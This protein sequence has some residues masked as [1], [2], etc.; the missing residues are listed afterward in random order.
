MKEKI[1]QAVKD[2]IPLEERYKENVVDG[3]K[4]KIPTNIVLSIIVITISLLMIV[5]S[6]VLLSSARAEQSDLEKGIKKLDSEIME[7]ENDLNKKNDG[8][9]IEFF[10][11]K[12][13]G[14]IKQEHVTAGYINS[15]KTDG[16]E[17]HENDNASLA[18]LIKWIFQNLK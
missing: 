15:N 13:L 1:K 9:D 12:V 2:W 6:S 10:A 5:G 14:M 4:T 18:S 3:K 7:L 11:E 17:K 16:V 8:I